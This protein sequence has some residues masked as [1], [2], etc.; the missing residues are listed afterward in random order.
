[1][2]LL[3]AVQLVLS[4]ALMAAGAAALGCLLS[5][6]VPFERAWPLELAGT[7]VVVVYLGWGPFRRWWRLIWGARPEFERMSEPG[8]LLPG[9]ELTCIVLGAGIG[10]LAFT[11]VRRRVRS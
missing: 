7:L 3:A 2:T 10:W 9:A 11:S 5:P 8:Y 1:M 4:A 6:L